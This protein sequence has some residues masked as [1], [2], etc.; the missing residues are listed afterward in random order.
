MGAAVAAA[1]CMG[2]GRNLADATGAPMH[3]FR[4]KP[5]KRI[6]VGIAGIGCRGNDAVH[7]LSGIPGVEVA[8]VC[9]VEPVR[10]DLCCDW[11]AK[12]G[13]PAPKR[14]VGAEASKESEISGKNGAS[15]FSH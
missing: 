2:A 7:R 5:M 6:R 3:G 13:K 12:H 8:A 11:L 10:L 15:F 9:D 4:E 14:F 1:G